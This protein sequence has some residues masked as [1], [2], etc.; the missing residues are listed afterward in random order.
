MSTEKPSFA[1]LVTKA[2][3]IAT[4]LS[5]HREYGEALAWAVGVVNDRGDLQKWLLW[6]YGGVGCGEAGNPAPPTDGRDLHACFCAISA[7]ICDLSP[8]RNGI[9]SFPYRDWGRQIRDVLRRDPTHRARAM[10]A[11]NEA[12]SAINDG[13][14]R[15]KETRSDDQFSS[16]GRVGRSEVWRTL[17]RR[18]EAGA[19]RY[20]GLTHYW[21]MWREGTSRP[22][23]PPLDLQVH[24]IGT[25]TCWAW[26]DTAGRRVVPGWESKHW[27]FRRQ[28][29]DWDRHEAWGDFERL[30][31]KAGDVLRRPGSG[32]T[33]EVNKRVISMPNRVQ[34]WLLTVACLEHP[35][36]KHPPEEVEG[37]FTGKQPQS[38]I[39]E[40]EDI[41]Q[42]SALACAELIE[43]STPVADAGLG[44][45]PGAGD[46]V[47]AK[48]QKD[49][50][51]A[52]DAA[53][54]AASGKV[55]GVPSPDDFTFESTALARCQGIDLHLPTG[56]CVQVL[57]VLVDRFG[58]PVAYAELNETAGS[59]DTPESEASDV[60]RGHIR[61]IRNSLKANSLPYCVENYRRHGYAVLPL[62]EPPQTP[63]IQSR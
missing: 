34:R 50:P 4:D 54:N 30:A 61:A 3:G 51:E 36:W 11:W 22:A 31:K 12:K 56:V 48:K 47:K 38:R 6:I 15:A 29:Q 25:N 40:V 21:L 33:P 58:R 8:G 28:G 7:I 52:R 19:N 42:S 37:I 5:K 26:I 10:G 1:E 62:T 16:Q 27:I 23:I 55:E 39:I 63:H 60:L 32:L 49:Q 24:K 20:P 41:W 53:S 2:E 13:I 9:K 14:H 45:G 46:E 35:D 44:V 59:L 43:H 17:Q 18:F 57:M